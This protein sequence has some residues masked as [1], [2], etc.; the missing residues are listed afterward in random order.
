M[1]SAEAPGRRHARRTRGQVGEL[2]LGCLATESCE[3]QPRDR[4]EAF[5]L[6]QPASYRML[7]IDVVGSKRE[8]EHDGSRTQIASQE[9]DEVQGGAVGPLDI[10]DQPD[11][12]LIGRELAQRRS[13]A[14]RTIAPDPSC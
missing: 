4:L 14:T 7:A 3:I 11:H 10:L 2:S 12:R 9:S 8:Q 1:R 6:A 13:A 5:E